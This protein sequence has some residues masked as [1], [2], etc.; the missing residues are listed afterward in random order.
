MLANVVVSWL[1][2]ECPCLKPL[3]NIVII[4]LGYRDM[5]RTNCIVSM[6]FGTGM[7]AQTMMISYVKLNAG[8]PTYLHSACA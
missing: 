8:R 3:T 6:P 4:V 5:S 7:L 1:L 2:V